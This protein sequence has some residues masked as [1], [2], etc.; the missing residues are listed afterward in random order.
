MSPV[1]PQDADGN[2]SAVPDPATAAGASLAERDLRKEI[3]RAKALCGQGQ[4]GE[5]DTI[6]SGVESKLQAL[7]IDSAEP[8]GGE[9]PAPSE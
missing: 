8:A 3:S 6:L 9:R 2:E 5:A 4:T 7:D 1:A